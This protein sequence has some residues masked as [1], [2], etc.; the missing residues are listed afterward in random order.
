MKIKEVVE[1]IEITEIIEGFKLLG[2]TTIYKDISAKNEKCRR[3]HR[4]HRHRRQSAATRE[5]C[6]TELV[7]AV[8]YKNSL[9]YVKIFS[10]HSASMVFNR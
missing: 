3:D 10:N 6:E 2:V 9:G 7:F 8:N 5:S 4:L 1:L